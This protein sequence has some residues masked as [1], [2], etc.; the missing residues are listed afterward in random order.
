MKKRCIII[1][2]LM[3]LILLIGCKAKTQCDTNC[4]KFSK[5][6]EQTYNKR[7]ISS[8]CKYLPELTNKL[9]E[10]DLNL[11]GVCEGTSMFCACKLDDGTDLIEFLENQR[12]AEREKIA[13]QYKEVILECQDLRLASAK[14]W[15]AMGFSVEGGI[16]RNYK[17]EFDMTTKKACFDKDVSNKCAAKCSEINGRLGSF[18]I[19]E[20]IT[21][22]CFIG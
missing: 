4:A 12:K 1:I 5:Q 20:V 8:E 21:C 3:V 18:K 2:L 15:E 19:D 16:A 22:N 14:E 10:P 7:I 17:N 11:L 6:L 13:E 9:S